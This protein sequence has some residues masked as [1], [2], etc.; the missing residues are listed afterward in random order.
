MKNN[1]LENHTQ[2][3]VSENTVKAPYAKP[4]LRIFGSVKQLTKGGG[5][6]RFDGNGPSKDQSI[7]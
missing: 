4:V 2:A 3:K 5:G 1:T 6:S 7:R